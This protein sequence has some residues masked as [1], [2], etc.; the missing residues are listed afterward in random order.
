MCSICIININVLVQRVIKRRVHIYIS[1][2][3]ERILFM[4]YND[5]F[6]GIGVAACT[7]AWA[8]VVREATPATFAAAFTVVGAVSGL[9]LIKHGIETVNVAMAISMAGLVGGYQLGLYVLF[10][11]AGAMHSQGL[12][13]LNVL[14]LMVYDATYNGRTYDTHAWIAFGI[15]ACA[16]VYTACAVGSLGKI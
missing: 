15:I 14:L 6:L 5:I 4:Y 9:Y 13:N 10:A 8:V 2:L 16:S 1:V 11:V 3:P 12:V 7:A